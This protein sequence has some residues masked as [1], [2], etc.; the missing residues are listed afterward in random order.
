[1]P[2]LLLDEPT[3]FLDIGHQLEILDLVRTLNREREMTIVLVLHD[4]NQAAR[5]SDRMVVLQQGQIVADGK[6]DAVLTRTCWRRSF[7]CMSTS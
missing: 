3:T 7:M 2:L 5:Y 6:P 1:M 4:L